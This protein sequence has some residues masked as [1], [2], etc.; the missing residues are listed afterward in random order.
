VSALISHLGAWTLVEPRTTLIAG[1]GP[2][3]SSRRLGDSHWEG[4][5]S[6]G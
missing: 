2:F 1:G 4:L 3:R 5:R 6:Y